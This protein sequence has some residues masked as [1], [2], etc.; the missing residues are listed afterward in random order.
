MLCASV[1]SLVYRREGFML[2]KDIRDN[3]LG[4]PFKH[5]GRTMDGLDCWGL[6]KLIYK[7]LG[8]ELLDIN[9]SYDLNWGWKGKNYFIENYW[10][11]WTKEEQPKL[12]DGVLFANTLDV[13]VHA[14]VYL[15]DNQIIHTCKM[16]TV[17][18]KISDVNRKYKLIGFYRLKAMQ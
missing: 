7:D 16:G 6:I 10:K 15:G 4:I 9:E 3:Y 5:Q 11:E 8:F 17:V 12:F 2:A 18:N 14:G 13:P 1:A